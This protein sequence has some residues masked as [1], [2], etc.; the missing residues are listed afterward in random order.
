MSSPTLSVGGSMTNTPDKSAD[1]LKREQAAAVCMRI[2]QAREKTPMKQPDMA[3]ALGVTPRTYQ[4]YEAT[5][6]GRPTI[7]WEHLDRIAELTG[8]SREWLL[9]D[10]SEA[11]SVEDA[12]RRIEAELRALRRVVLEGPRVPP[13]RDEDDA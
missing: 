6:K 12:L 9:G 1:D 7:P 10:A 8:V 11:S 5:A 13:G 2:K 3:R 4:N